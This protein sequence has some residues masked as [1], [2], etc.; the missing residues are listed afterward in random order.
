MNGTLFDPIN[1]GCKTAAMFFC[2]QGYK[3]ALGN[4]LM[5]IQ[6]SSLLQPMLRW[7]RFSKEELH[8]LLN[9]Y[10]RIV[11]WSLRGVNV[12]SLQRG[13][14]E[15]ISRLRSGS[16][17]TGEDGSGSS[18][19]IARTTQ[20][21]MLVA[22]KPIAIGKGTAP[23][24][25][26]G[27][28]YMASGATMSPIS[29][30]MGGFGTHTSNHSSNSSSVTGTAAPQLTRASTNN[31]F[32]NGLYHN[33]NLLR[34][35]HYTIK[36]LGRLQETYGE[37]NVEHALQL[38]INILCSALEQY[39]RG[40]IVDIDR[41]LPPS[42]RNH[43]DFIIDVSKFIEMW[44]ND[45]LGEIADKL[46]LCEREKS[47]QIVD[48]CLARIFEILTEKDRIYMELIKTASK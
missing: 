17:A 14:D 37:G 33:R 32:H 24:S 38:M 5:Q 40:E 36:G 15:G 3:V 4:N 31:V 35:L 48:G 23:K 19:D 18:E 7:F 16:D 25:P 21:H 46:E 20:Q 30:L 10:K 9:S 13:L 8:M 44:D 41:Q 6:P 27:S 12:R 45:T 29:P 39:E 42:V 22:S 11:D 1:I 34:I 26:Y 43:D 2:H 28:S 47:Q